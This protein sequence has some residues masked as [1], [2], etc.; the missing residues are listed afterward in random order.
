MAHSEDH[1]SNTEGLNARI[2]RLNK[3]ILTLETQEKNLTTQSSTHFLTLL[4]S[5]KIDSD[6]EALEKVQVQNE[7]TIKKLKSIKEKKEHEKMSKKKND[8]ENM[9]K[10]EVLK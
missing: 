6:I 7:E 9:R 3:E 1:K 2:D 10:F 5:Q 8:E 4:E